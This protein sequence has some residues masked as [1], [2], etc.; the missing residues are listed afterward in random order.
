MN[1]LYAVCNDFKDMDICVCCI[2]G[3]REKAK[4]KIAEYKRNFEQSGYDWMT[5]HFWIREIPAT[6]GP[7]DCVEFD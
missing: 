4:D 7:D 3:S 5:P 6:F 2:C 1:K